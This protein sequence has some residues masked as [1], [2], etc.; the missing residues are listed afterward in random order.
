M[1]WTK[2]PYLRLQDCIK[3]EVCNLYNKQVS[4]IIFGISESGDFAL[5]TQVEYNNAIRLAEMFS[6]IPIYLRRNVAKHTFTISYFKDRI[7]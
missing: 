2:S 5:I 7:L 3:T 4:F 1:F 6:K